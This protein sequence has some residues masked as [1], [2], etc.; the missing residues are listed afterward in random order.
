MLHEHCDREEWWYGCATASAR[1]W[2]RP[3]V[4]LSVVGPGVA[5][6]SV[7]SLTAGASL[8]RPP[9]AVRGTTRPLHPSQPAPPLQHCLRRHRCSPLLTCTA[10]L[11][12]STLQRVLATVANM[13]PAVHNPRLVVT[14]RAAVRVL[15]GVASWAACLNRGGVAQALCTHASAPLAPAKRKLDAVMEADPPADAKRHAAEPLGAGPITPTAPEVLPAPP[16][17]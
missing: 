2:L 16:V 11:L 6:K 5:A 15:I 1:G 9:S 17:A 4:I 14:R 10:L 12:Q 3:D 7:S 8:C 13:Q